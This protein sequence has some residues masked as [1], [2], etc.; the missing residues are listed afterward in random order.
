M[1]IMNHMHVVHLTQVNEFLCD[2][3]KRVSARVRMRTRRCWSLGVAHRRSEFMGKRAL[4]LL[5]FSGLFVWFIKI[6]V[7]SAKRSFSCLFLKKNKTS[8]QQLQV[9]CS[10]CCVKLALSVPVARI[11]YSPLP[12]LPPPPVP[13]WR[14]TRCRW[15]CG[16]RRSRGR[17]RAWWRMRWSMEEAAEGT[18]G[19]T[20]RWPEEV[21]EVEAAEAGGSRHHPRTCAPNSSSTRSSRTAAQPAASRASP[22]S[23]SCTPKSPRC[24]ISARRRWNKRIYKKLFSN[25]DLRAHVTVNLLWPFTLKKKKWEY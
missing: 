16:E 5:T 12:S 8:P 11:I 1:V 6:F 25:V 22:T 19:R 24:L 2:V 15:A 3:G 17:V 9:V 20:Q 4:C 14:S 21:E 18:R 13:W 10:K 23:K 7:Y